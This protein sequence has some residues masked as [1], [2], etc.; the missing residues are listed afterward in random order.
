MPEIKRKSVNFGFLEYDLEKQ[1]S[2]YNKEVLLNVV[3]YL[4]IVLKHH[5]VFQKPSQKNEMVVRQ[6]T[7]RNSSSR[8][9]IAKCLRNI[10]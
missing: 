4:L 2:K 7:I 1:K 9:Y 10:S 3:V 6:E 8:N 5:Q